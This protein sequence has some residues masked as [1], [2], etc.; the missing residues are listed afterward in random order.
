MRFTLLLLLYT[1]I[2]FPNNGYTQFKYPQDYFR[3]P[4]EGR[5][6]LSG[7]FGE[8]RSNHFHAGI[9][10]KTGGVVGKNVYAAAD[11][12]ISRIKI[13]PWGYG[14]AIYIDHPNGYTSVYGH[15]KEIKGEVSKYVKAQQY[16]QQSFAVDLYFKKDQFKL[17]KSDVIALSGNSGGSGGPHVHFEIRDSDTQEPIN[18]LLFGIEVKDFITPVI[19]SIRIYPAQYNGT[20]GQNTKPTSFDLRGWGA[21]YQLKNLDTLNIKGD[22]YLGIN[23]V[24][25]QND[26]RNNNGVFSITLLVDDSLYYK[27]Q[28]ERLSFASNRD[29]N[30]LIDYYYYKKH[31]RRYQRTYKSPNNRLKLYQDIENQGILSLN[32]NKY[33]EIKYQVQDAKG[34]TS[35]LQFVIFSAPIIK[36]KTKKK[37]R[38]NFYQPLSKHVFSNNEVE[39]VF[40]KNCLYDTLSFHYSSNKSKKNDLSPI[41]SIAHATI[42]LQQ[43]INIQLKSLLI[44]DSL[45][46][47]IYIERIEKDKSTTYMGKWENDSYL[48]STKNFGDY[49]LQ[50]DSIKPS[51]QLKNTKA[52]RPNTLIFIAKDKGSGIS[53][54]DCWINGKWEI[55]QYDPK[56]N[57]MKL[58][59]PLNLQKINKLVLKITD[60]VGN[61]QK[62]NLTI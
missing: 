2:L 57:R 4:I 40:P 5:L 38:S 60:K 51:I 35:I 16:A 15:L 14:N 9:D 50:I 54:Y 56:T 26:S 28:M 7:T 55:L 30:T 19:R 47:K 34:N 10:I 11:G 52:N 39:I 42:P 31:K 46:P 36:Q 43:K 22:F 18:P 21:T 8:L 3:P 61:T 25:K 48:F 49:Q 58:D 32:D 23:T 6:Y 20:I 27:H 33:H 29:I 1:A 53:T 62:L 44:S 24:D 37:P 59:L 45:K 13:S 17:Q 12:W 41:F